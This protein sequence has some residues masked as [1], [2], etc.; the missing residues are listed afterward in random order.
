[1]VAITSTDAR[2]ERLRALGAQHVINSR[3]QSNWGDIAKSLTP[4]KRGVD[5]IIDVVGLKTLSEDLW[6]IDLHGGTRRSCE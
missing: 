4:E 5:H 3:S 1:M 6:P 2:A